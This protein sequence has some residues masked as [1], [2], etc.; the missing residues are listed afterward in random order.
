MNRVI[1]Q[2]PMLP[3]A[4]RQCPDRGIMNGLCLRRDYPM[5]TYAT[6]W[7]ALLAGEVL[8]AA[9]LVV[10]RHHGATSS[11]RAPK[12]RKSPTLKVSSRVTP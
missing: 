2:P 12:R 10:E 4:G 11:I 7:L 5:S 3:T 1:E 6:R 9:V 8:A